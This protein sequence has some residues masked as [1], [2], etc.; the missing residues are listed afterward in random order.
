M[1]DK[2]AMT[3]IFKFQHELLRAAKMQRERVQKTE[4]EVSMHMGEESAL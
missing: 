3:T 2:I 4:K 1:A